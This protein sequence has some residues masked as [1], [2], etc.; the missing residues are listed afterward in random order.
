MVFI[1]VFN[2]F[3][4]YRVFLCMKHSRAMQKTQSN[5]QRHGMMNALL[6]NGQNTCT[7]KRKLQCKHPQTYEEPSQEQVRRHSRSA[8]GR[9]DLINSFKYNKP[10]PALPSGP[11]TR[12]HKHKL[13]CKHVKTTNSFKYTKP[14]PVKSKKK[15]PMFQNREHDI[16]TS[17]PP[18][19]RIQC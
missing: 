2:G 1:P 10:R 14:R 16:N 7:H 8:V 11:N 9:A 18:S 5:K 6:P 19:P 3:H 12:T 13:Q 17:Q 15:P 4:G